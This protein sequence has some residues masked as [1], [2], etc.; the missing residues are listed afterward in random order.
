M[1]GKRLRGACPIAWAVFVFSNALLVNCG[2]SSKDEQPEIAALASLLIGNANTNDGAVLLAI[3]SAGV[4]PLDAPPAQDPNLVALGRFLFFDKELS[5][6]RNIACASC[7]LPAAF[8][9]DRLPT[10]I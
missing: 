6:D 7:H 10:S 1:N 3:R 2:A 4:T 8:T 5:G 9:G